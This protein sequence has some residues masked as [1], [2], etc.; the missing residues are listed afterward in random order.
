MGRD[1]WLTAGGVARKHFERLRGPGYHPPAAPSWRHGQLLRRPP[2]STRCRLMAAARFRSRRSWRRLKKIPQTTQSQ[3]RPGAQNSWT[4][5]PSGCCSR[6]WLPPEHQRQRQHQDFTHCAWHCCLSVG[7]PPAHHV[8]RLNQNMY[9]PGCCHPPSNPQV[10][11]A[12]LRWLGIYA[13]I[14]ITLGLVPLHQNLTL[15]G[16]RALHAYIAYMLVIRS[17]KNCIKN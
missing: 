12:P 13:C 2:P 7:I 3:N 1:S 9:H 6:R 4:C 11:Q 10:Q 15:L 14:M 17:I 16:A 8:N 5:S